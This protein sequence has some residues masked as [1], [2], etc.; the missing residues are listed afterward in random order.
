MAL[1][2]AMLGLF[3]GALLAC[4]IFTQDADARTKY[5]TYKVLWRNTVPGCSKKNPTSCRLPI[6]ANPPEN[7]ETKDYAPLMSPPNNIN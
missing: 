3:L 4:S 7:G 6:A 5:I 1:P 2:K